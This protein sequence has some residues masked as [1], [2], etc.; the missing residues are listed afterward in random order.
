MPIEPTV[1]SISTAILISDKNH[2][3]SI[4]SEDGQF[5]RCIGSYGCDEG[6]LNHPYGIA[7]NLNSLYVADWVNQREFKYLTCS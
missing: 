6:Q 3:V 1:G 7:S 2:R 4:F 5:M